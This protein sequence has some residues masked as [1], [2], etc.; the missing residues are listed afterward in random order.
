VA[1]SSAFDV[2]ACLAGEVVHYQA[3]SAS[4]E[5]IWRTITC[6]LPPRLDTRSLTTAGLPLIST[7]RKRLVDA[8]TDALG[9]GRVEYGVQVEAVD[10]GPCVVRSGGQAW[11]A[12]L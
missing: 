9:D 6:L 12:G 5:S 3:S 4:S 7:T 11:E 8:L 10:T 2:D 1:R